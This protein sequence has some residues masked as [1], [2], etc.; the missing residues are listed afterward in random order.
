MDGTM[1]R[2]LL[3]PAMLLLLV[4]SLPTYADGINGSLNYNLYQLSASAEDEID[5]DLMKVT[6]LASHQAPQ[7][8][9]A[10]NVVNRQMTE[11]LGILKATKN[12]QYQTGN[13]HTQPV[14]QNQQIV[15]WKASQNLELKSADVNQLSDVLA[16]LQKELKISSINFDI[17]QAVRQ[18]V[19]NLLSVDVLN[20]FK[21]RAE[22]IQKTMGAIRYKIVSLNLNTGS[23]RPSFGRTLMRSEMAS[24][25]SAPAVESG[26]GTINVEL[27]GQ[28]QLIFN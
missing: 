11:A 8:F 13:Y 25:S 3:I 22:L 27:S 2:P 10:S 4:S 12:V 15:G 17:S 23:Q 16:E 1:M 14:Y 20:R 21:E 26:K 19:E 28:I 6:L 7:T 9:E 18:E 5:N 24:V